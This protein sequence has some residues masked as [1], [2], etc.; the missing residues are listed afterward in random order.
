[1][2]VMVL[3]MTTPDSFAAAIAM[4]LRAELGRQNHSR[5]WLAEQVGHSHVTVSRWLND[6]HM[7]LGALGEM[8][9]ALGIEAAELVAT[10]HRGPIPRQR[11]SDDVPVAA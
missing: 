4:E 5:R 2:S 10:A 8:C 7:P 11:R 9:N 6:G 3:A 1:M